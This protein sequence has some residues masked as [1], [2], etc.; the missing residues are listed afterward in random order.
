[1]SSSGPGGVLVFLSFVLASALLVA[2]YGM[3]YVGLLAA[4]G[5]AAG[6]AEAA[7]EQAII[8]IFGYPVSASISGEAVRIQNE[9]R[10]VIQ[11]VGRG[12]LQYDRLLAIGRDSEIVAEV[13]LRGRGLGSGQ[14]H[15]YRASELGLPEKYDNFTIFRSE[16]QRLVLLSTRGRTHGSMWGVPSFLES[17][18]EARLTGTFTTTHTYSYGTPTTYTSTFTVPFTPPQ[19]RYS[20]T[21]EVWV[22]VDGKNW[23]K[24]VKGWD[25]YSGPVTAC[26]TDTFC[27]SREYSPD[28]GGYSYARKWLNNKCY[29]GGCLTRAGPPKI[30]GSNIMESEDGQQ[31]IYRIIYVESGRSITAEAG[32]SFWQYGESKI[33]LY[34]SYNDQYYW[35]VTQWGRQFVPQAIELVDWDTGE[36]IGSTNSTSMTFEAGRNT[37]ARFKYVKAESWSRTWI[38]MP[39]RSATS[40]ID[41]DDILNDPSKKGGSEWCWCAK[42]FNHP[43]YWDYCGATYRFCLTGPVKPCCVG[44]DSATGCLNSWSSSAGQDC[45]DFTEKEYRNGVTKSVEI[46]WSASWSLKP[47]WMFTGVGKYSVGGEVSCSATQSDSSLSGACSATVPPNKHVYITVSFKKTS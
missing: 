2:I 9:T 23:G 13:S 12:E 30:D 32:N 15:L 37:I 47:G 21:G 4:A 42:L 43:E 10:I 6:Q 19:S 5:G 22:S 46:S 38:I 29:G 40:P 36:V 33:C 27:D 3:V 25:L 18:L 14:W 26:G 35:K 45:K 41:C 16:V 24:V 7:A 34:D 17:L 28:C 11:N 8:Y 20:M 31:I 39:P 1:M 44:A